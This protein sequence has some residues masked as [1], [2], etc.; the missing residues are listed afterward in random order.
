MTFHKHHSLYHLLGIESD[1]DESAIKKA[2]RKK[3]LLCHPDKNP[4]NPKAAETFHEITEA[5]SIL[6]DKD[7]RKA[8][9]QACSSAAEQNVN[10]QQ[11]TFHSQDSTED[12]RTC[13]SNDETHCY[14]GHKEEPPPRKSSSGQHNIKKKSFEN[15]PVEKF[16]G[17]SNNVAIFLISSILCM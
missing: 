4:N 1:A 9:D 15:K 12:I 2:Y 13:P 3:A 5:Y 14:P 7:T 17:S 10:Q 8:Y 11:Q 6:T 16:N